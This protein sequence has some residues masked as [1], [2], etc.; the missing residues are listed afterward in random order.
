M[1]SPSREVT[2][3][4]EIVDSATSK[5]V[6]GVEVLT[7]SGSIEADFAGHATITVP[8]GAPAA[9]TFGRLGYEPL[10]EVV[11]ASGDTQR[12]FRMTARPT[13]LARTKSGR[14]YE[15][16]A[17]SLEFGYAVPFL[18]Y[19]KG[20]QIKACRSGGAEVILDNTTVRKLSGPA[21]SNI[22]LAC[23]QRGTPVGLEVELTSGEKVRAYFRDFCEGH[24]TEIIGHDQI[25]WQLVFIPVTELTE[26]T[27]RQ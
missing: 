23:C 10:T 27:V 7:P 2:L 1:I 3:V 25:S 15:I 5:P 22:E 24:Q 8:A 20:A 9:L 6:V 26:L 14:T 18:G 16:A 4:V 13:T 12:T 17:G 21:F 19:I 11:T